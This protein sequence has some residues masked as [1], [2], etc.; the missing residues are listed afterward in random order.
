MAALLGKAISSLSL[1]ITRFMSGKGNRTKDPHRREGDTRTINNDL[2]CPTPQF[3]IPLEA[4]TW[5]FRRI[6][7]SWENKREAEG[8]TGTPGVR[9]RAPIRPRGCNAKG[10]KSFINND[11]WNKMP[12]KLRTFSPQTAPGQPAWTEN[13]HKI[14]GVFRA[15]ERG[16]PV[17]F[18]LRDRRSRYGI[19]SVFQ[20]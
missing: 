13:P 7:T 5:Y 19:E 18:F 12:Q 3:R 2:S 9:T 17:L 1:D 14:W 10:I 6:Q 15:R 8:L 16:H 11:C 20:N 4:N